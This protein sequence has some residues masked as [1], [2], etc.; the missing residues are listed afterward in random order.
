VSAPFDPYRTWLGIPAEEQ[1]PNHYRLLNLG[2][3]EDDP[4]VIERAAEQ[5]VGILHVFQTGEH[6]KV[7]VKLLNE[8]A[9]AKVCLLNPNRKAGYDAGVRRVLRIK[10]EE[11][12]RAAAVEAERAAVQRAL[13]TRF[14]AVLKQK[15]L[16]PGGLFESLRKQTAD[17]KK[18]LSAATLAKG[19]IE[20]GLLTP[21]LAERLLTAAEE[22][23]YPPGFAP[24]A[25]MPEK[26]A[27]PE[28]E[29]EELGLAPLEEEQVK[30]GFPPL[31]EDRPAAA[32]TGSLVDEEL[33]PLAEE[34]EDPGGIDPLDGLQAYASFAAVGSPLAPLAPSKKGLKGLFERKRKKR[35]EKAGVWDSSLMLVGG[36]ALLVLAILGA[37]L[38]LTLGR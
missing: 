18:V 25:A 35:N 33:P 31:K 12:E 38:I 29:E 27:P 28:R 11:A 5:R 4:A 22:E 21:V 10:A 13:C 7:A 2:L 17:S 6:A 30:L 37:V 34:Y 8:V 14:L 20:K 19:L 26:Q 9:Q 3:F 15:A 16:L 32:V 1:P 24:A 23:D 36:G